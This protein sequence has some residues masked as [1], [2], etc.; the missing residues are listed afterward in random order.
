MPKD[1]KTSAKDAS[2]AAEILRDP[3][4]TKDEKSVAGSDLSQRASAQPKGTSAKDA[5]K[6][7]HI[8]RD[9]KATK[10][11]KSVAG[12]DLSQ[13]AGTQPKKK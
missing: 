10:D 13:R 1:R 8:L 3:K 11:E 12:S 4:A 7:A 6:A 2:K 5:S 9:P